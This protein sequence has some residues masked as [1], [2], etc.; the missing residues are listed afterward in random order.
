MPHVNAWMKLLAM[1]QDGTFQSYIVRTMK[2]DTWVR[3]G[4]W[5]VPM[6]SRMPAQCQGRQVVIAAL[7]S[8]VDST[9]PPHCAP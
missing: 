6:G 7:V 2:G 1:A 3:F 4:N 8:T 5:L 9:A